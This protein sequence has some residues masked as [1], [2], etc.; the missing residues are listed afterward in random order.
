MNKQESLLK[1]YMP[2][3]QSCAI[4]NSCP[5][6]SALKFLIVMQLK[7]L[8]I[9]RKSQKC[10]L[11]EAL[12]LDDLLC[13]KFKQDWEFGALESVDYISRHN[14]RNFFRLC[15]SLDLPMVNAPFVRK[16]TRIAFKIMSQNRRILTQDK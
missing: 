4:A 12:I 14:Q 8:S 11:R 13:L 2:T 3:K 6:R 16:T 9:I 15:V 7:C 5:L 1:Q 10:V